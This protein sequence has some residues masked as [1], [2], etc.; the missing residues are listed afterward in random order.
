MA[1]RP[2]VWPLLP[3]RLHLPLLSLAS[4]PLPHWSPCFHAVPP[5]PDM[6]QPQCLCTC[7]F[8]CWDILLSYTYFK[9]LCQH[10]FKE[11]PLT[12]LSKIAIPVFPAI[13]YFPYLTTFYLHRID[14]CCIFSYCL[15]YTE[16][17]LQVVLFTTISPVPMSAWHEELSKSSMN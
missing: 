16:L 5:P 4:S 6:F 7:F 8:L 12:I 2:A 13:P 3:H 14:H 11:L 15:S 10:H 9:S 1:H 17:K